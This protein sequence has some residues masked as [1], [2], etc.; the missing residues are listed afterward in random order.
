M[1]ASFSSPR[2]GE[3]G[4]EGGAEGGG[5]AS[6]HGRSSAQG[7]LGKAAAARCETA[8]GVESAYLYV[9]ERALRFTET[10]RVARRQTRI[11]GKRAGPGAKRRGPA[12]VTER[13][14]VII[15][16]LCV[17]SDSER[18]YSY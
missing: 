3:R 5:R 15:F 18:S 8:Q 2:G 7:S 9:R 17:R 10:K 13:E 12:S 4:G 16:D 6:A 14:E 11:V 1:L